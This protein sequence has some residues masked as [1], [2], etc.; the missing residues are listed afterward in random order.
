MGK[1]INHLSPEEIVSKTEYWNQRIE[2]E[3]PIS[4]NDLCQLVRDTIRVRG[5]KGLNLV[6]VNSSEFKTSDYLYLLIPDQIEEKSARVFS[7]PRENDLVEIFD[8]YGSGL[9]DNPIRTIH[10]SSGYGFNVNT[11]QQVKLSDSERKDIAK[12]IWQAHLKGIPIKPERINF[13]L[14]SVLF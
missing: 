1:E 5:A 6:S 12:T 9:N 13:P 3:S 4:N 10:Y 14:F 11:Q 2:S 8:F 7:I